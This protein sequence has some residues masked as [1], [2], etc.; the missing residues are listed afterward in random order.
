MRHQD[1]RPLVCVVSG[2][3]PLRLGF[4]SASSVRQT[5]H[6]NCD[7]SDWQAC[8]SSRMGSLQISLLVYLLLMGCV[9]ERLLLLPNWWSLLLLGGYVTP[10]IS[11]RKWNEKVSYCFMEIPGQNGSQQIKKQGG[12]CQIICY[13]SLLF[14]GKKINKCV[15]V[16]EQYIHI[17]QEQ[18][19]FLHSIVKSNDGHQ[20]I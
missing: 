16:F 11:K 4:L 5:L 9:R 3:V 15:V 2:L 7:E 17:W 20:L 19:A 6:I 13:K 8:D 10:N 1:S 14:G 12:K 18:M